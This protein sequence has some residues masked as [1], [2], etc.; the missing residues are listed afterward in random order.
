M[1]MTRLYDFYGGIRYRSAV[2]S[3][4]LGKYRSL[5]NQ[6]IQQH[7]ITPRYINPFESI[8]PLKH[9]L[10]RVHPVEYSSWT[11][12]S[13]ILGLQLLDFPTLPG[14][15]K[16]KP[17]QTHNKNNRLQH[18]EPN[19]K[20]TMPLVTLIDGMVRFLFGAECYNLVFLL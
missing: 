17:T 4:K 3:S 18:P 11:E 10:L 16:H 14:K 6:T 15:T 8:L 20:R 7:T 1:T 5:S 19:R 9:H 12:F 13:K 2:T